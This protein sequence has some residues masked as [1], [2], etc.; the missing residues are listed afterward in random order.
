MSLETDLKNIGINEVGEY[1]KNGSY[2][3]DLKDDADFGRMYSLLDT[4]YNVEQEDDSV[5]LTRHNAQLIYTY[6]NKYQ[7]VLKADFDNNLYS[8]VCNDLK[9][10]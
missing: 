3:I 2:V 8:L 4:S 1:S 9:N 7:L 5:L 10:L 6:D